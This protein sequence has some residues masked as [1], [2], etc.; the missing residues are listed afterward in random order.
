V[1]VADAVAVGV[2]VAVAVAVLVAVAVGVGVA[3]AVA[4]A[5]A[6]DVGVLVAVAVGV[7][8]GPTS[9]NAP[10]SHLPG[11]P[12]SGS[13][14]FTPRWSVAMTVVPSASVQK[15]VGLVGM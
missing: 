5:V 13:G 9:S 14:R 4:V 10:M 8:V 6:V 2:L 3:V 7:A 11:V 15:L 12:S 1:D